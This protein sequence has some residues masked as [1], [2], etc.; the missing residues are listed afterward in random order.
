M[1]QGLE[2]QIKDL[3]EEERRVIELIREVVLEA[4]EP[5]IEQI[6]HQAPLVPMPQLIDWYRVIAQRRFIEVTPNKKPIYAK[7]GQVGEI[8]FYTTVSVVSIVSFENFGDGLNVQQTINYN[9]QG[10]RDAKNRRIMTIDAVTP[11]PLNGEIFPA[12]IDLRIMDIVKQ[13]LFDK[14]GYN[15][16]DLMHEHLY[17]KRI[18]P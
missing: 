15:I 9:I 11:Y 8:V 14:L 4:N 3:R 5:L 16:V 1:L 7:F 2:G 10:N 17:S 13:R 12:G 18:H 6:L